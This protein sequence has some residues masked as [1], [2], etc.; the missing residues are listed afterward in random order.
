MSL[1]SVLLLL[2][3]LLSTALVLNARHPRHAWWNVLVRWPASW[4][5]RELTPLLVV[6]GSLCTGLLVAL[7]ALD[8]VTGIVGAGLVAA[9]VAVGIAWSLTAR[10]ARVSVAGQV[11]DLDLDDGDDARRVPFREIAIPLLMLR[12][13]DVRHVRGVRFT[14][15]DQR[16]RKLD[17]YLPRDPAPA[18]T[19]RP[20]IVQVHGGGWVVGSRKEQGIPLLNHL[21]RCGWVGF[22]VDYR[23]SPFATWPE[24]VVDVKRAI[25]WV[26]EHAE[27]YDVDPDFVAI[28]GGSAG[29]HLTALAALT[30]HDRTLQ[31]GF[32]DAD[33]SVQAAVP[34]YGVYDLLDEERTSLPLLHPWVLEPLVLKRRRASDPDAF[35][36]ASP[37]HRMTA[38][39]P[40]MLVVHGDADSLIPVAQARTFVEEL[41]ETS[42]APVAYLELQ[43]GEHAFD[44]IPSW[45]TAPVVETIERFLRTVHARRSDG[46]TAEVERDVAQALTD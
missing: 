6:G 39:A 1:P 32:E 41:R 24:H 10:G 15:D 42:R 29:G 19:R 9:S 20:A 28:T 17:V 13:R 33:T 14:D 23:L 3:G 16:P 5:A 38:D 21:A 22:N 44:V 12:A 18:G 27:E 8:G 37:R 2:F 11:S 31:P 46:T 7:G 45:R 40:P 35:R 43:G 34:F 25:A 26:R 4:V 30:P 36:A